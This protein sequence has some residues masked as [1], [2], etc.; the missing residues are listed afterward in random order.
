MINFLFWNVNSRR[1][2]VGRLVYT[3]AVDVL[4]LAE[5]TTDPQEIVADIE[6]GGS[7]CFHHD[8]LC[9][10]GLAMFTR[11]PRQ[12]VNVELD[13][14]HFSIR[15]L[16]FAPADILLVMLHFPSKLRKTD[17]EQSALCPEYV[18]EIR[19]IETKVGHQRTVLVGD[20]NMNPFETGMVQ[21]NGFHAVMSR[22]VA[23]RRERT[24]DGRSYP[25]F[26]N[27]MWSHFG[28]ARGAPPGTFYRDKGDMISFF[29]HMYDQVLI[30][31]DLIDRFVP[32]Q[33]QIITQCDQEA[34]ID[35][36]GEPNVSDHLPLFF[37][38]D[39]TVPSSNS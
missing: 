33:L 22:T 34:L 19:A 17:A 24:V 31:P 21:A 1:N 12:F 8:P 28:D 6:Q 4:V 20:L 18:R 37:Q 35:A 25:L 7:G 39:L 3:H 23:A 29:W 26:Y 38:M 2:L 13:E 11:F 14:Q 30:R 15:R 16:R 32:S 9:R 36:R 27:P 5:S 10:G